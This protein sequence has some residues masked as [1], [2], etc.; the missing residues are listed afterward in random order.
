MDTHAQLKLGRTIGGGTFGK[1]RRA[2]HTPTNQP[3]AVKI[4]QKSKITNKKDAL[5]I[6]REISILKKINHPN[7]LKLLQLI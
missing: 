2:I 7:L 6:Q 4:L 5:R 1:V 3:V